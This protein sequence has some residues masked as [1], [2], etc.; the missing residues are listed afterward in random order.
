MNEDNEEHGQPTVTVIPT[1]GDAIV[2]ET[3]TV[4]I[5]EPEERVDISPLVS[6]P[7]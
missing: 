2:F 7:K 1:D 4:S 6:V 3:P 5:P